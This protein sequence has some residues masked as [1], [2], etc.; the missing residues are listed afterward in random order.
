MATAYRPMNIQSRG[1]NK[2]AKDWDEKSEYGRFNDL[3]IV[4]DAKVNCRT[5]I[6]GALVKAAYRRYIQV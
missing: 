4:Q 1:V 3:R 5:L 2:K 6:F